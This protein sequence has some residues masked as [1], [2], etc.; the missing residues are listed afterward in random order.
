[1][2]RDE[3]VAE[4]SF[5]PN[6]RWYRYLS[7][8]ALLTGTVIGLVA[9]PFWLLGGWWWSTRYYETLDCVLGER[10]LGVG[11]GI[12][13]RTEKSIPL[14]Q[15]QDV[16]VTHGPVLKWFGLTKLK[17][18]TAGESAGQEAAAK[19]IGVEEPVAFRDRVL[20]Q[21]ERVSDQRTGS[22][23]TDRTGDDVSTLLAEIRDTLGRIEEKLGDE[24]IV[25]G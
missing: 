3:P 21:R 24:G 9:L 20:Q 14:D 13:F 1:M 10:S 6:L 18:K 8:A 2:S 5:H 11:Y 23:D 7:I 17:V 19:L 16:A 22:P 4:A 25:E 12:L 15:I